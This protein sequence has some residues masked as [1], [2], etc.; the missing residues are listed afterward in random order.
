MA[1]LFEAAFF[2]ILDSRE[3]LQLNLCTG[4]RDSG[5]PKWQW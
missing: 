3:Y 5:A 4:L 2:D 1:D